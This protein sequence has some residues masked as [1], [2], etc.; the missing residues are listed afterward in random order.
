MLADGETG[1]WV[2]PSRMT[3]EQLEIELKAAGKPIP[4]DAKRAELAALV[5]V[6]GLGWYRG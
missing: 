3:L 4:P 6:G 5:K 2:R 1:V